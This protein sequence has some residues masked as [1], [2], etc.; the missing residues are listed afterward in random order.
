M[1]VNETAYFE[2]IGKVTNA[3]LLDHFKDLEIFEILMTYQ[4]HAN[5]RTCWK[6]NKNECFVLIN[7]L[8]GRDLFQNHSIVN[9]VLVK[10]KR[11]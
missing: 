11:F 2:F 5:S 4:V 9:L 10:S 8:L 7:I 3:H 6:Y 1:N